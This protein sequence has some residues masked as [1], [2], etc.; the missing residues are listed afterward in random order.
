MIQ[1]PHLSADGIIRLYDENEEFQGIVFI[2]RLNEPFGIALPGGF[3]DI[4]EKVE[5][6]LVREMKEEVSLD[7]QIESLL[8]VYSDPKRDPRFHTATA[9]YI[10]KAIGEPKA[11]DDAK[12]VFVYKI[13]DIPY[14]KLVFDH[15]EIVEDFIKET[16]S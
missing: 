13:E 5:D 16:T 14:D 1:T 11:C 9:V 6:A 7:V 10:C 15:K 8:G 3:V 12:S 2:E 4:G